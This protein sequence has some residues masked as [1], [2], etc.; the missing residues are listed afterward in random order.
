MVLQLMQLTED[1][2]EWIKTRHGVRIL[3]KTICAM[4]VEREEMKGQQPVLTIKGL[5]I[6]CLVLCGR[7]QTV[8]EQ[9][10]RVKKRYKRVR[11]IQVK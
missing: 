5:G 10:A 1:E 11:C 3:K 8:T 9:Y 4:R 2:P 6:V 7:S